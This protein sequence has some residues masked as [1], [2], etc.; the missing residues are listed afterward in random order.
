MRDTHLPLGTHHSGTELVALGLQP[1]VRLPPV[2]LLVLALQR[3]GVGT[4]VGVGAGGGIVGGVEGRD[5]GEDG[6]LCEG[7]EG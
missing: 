1:V 2:P 4:G 3:I 7:G 5:G 6:E